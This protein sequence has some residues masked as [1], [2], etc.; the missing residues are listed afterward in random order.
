[1]RMTVTKT[2]K[3]LDFASRASVVRP[4]DLD[5]LGIPR[6]YLNRLVN[7]GQLHK[8]E[9]GLYSAAEIST[10]AHMS[11]VQVMRKASRAVICLLSALRFHEIGT[12]LPS[13]VWIAIDVK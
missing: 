10:S 8:L 3:L 4:R 11:L 12:Q 1:M 9:R 5:R 2:A 6:N 7:R 13:E